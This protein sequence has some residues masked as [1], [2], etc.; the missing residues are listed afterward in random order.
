MPILLIIL[1]NF[2][3]QVYALISSHYNKRRLMFY[4]FVKVV[5]VPELGYSGGL[6]ILR[7]DGKPV[8][9][10]CTAPV[11]ENRAQ[12]IL[13]GSTYDQFV[14]CDQIGKALVTK[15]SSKP[16]IIITDQAELLQMV[17]LISKPV[18]FVSPKPDPANSNRLLEVNAATPNESFSIGEHDLR[19]ASEDLQVCHDVKIACE[20]FAAKLPLD[21]PFERIRQAIDEAQAVA[22]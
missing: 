1:S 8:E 14:F 7:D 20:R 17:E 18:V 12:K 19:L 3:S 2:G 13:Y 21:E 9:F 6:L 4:G 10:H 22:R 5:A 11:A 16:E 15:A